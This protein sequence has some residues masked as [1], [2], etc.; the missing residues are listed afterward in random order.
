MACWQRLIP[1]VLTIL[2]SY[3]M[4]AW[5]V[6]HGKHLFISRVLRTAGM[7]RCQGISIQA[8]KPIKPIIPPLFQNNN[9]L[10]ALIECAGRREG[11]CLFKVALKQDCGSWHQNG[12]ALD[13]LFLTAYNKHG[14]V[15][16]ATTT[17]EIC[18]RCLPG[19]RCI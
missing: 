7:A 10:L 4:W 13:Y 11:E 19:K 3:G 15:L 12:E 14:T 9:I 5:M 16:K 6:A 2:C 8:S 1:A 18:R 17:D